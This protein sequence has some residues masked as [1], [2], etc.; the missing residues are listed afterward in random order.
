VSRQAEAAESEG[1]PLTAE[2]RRLVKDTRRAG[3]RVTHS[4]SPAEED[5]LCQELIRFD[6]LSMS[7]QEN[8]LDQPDSTWSQ[9]LWQYDGHF[10]T[11]LGRIT[12]VRAPAPLPP[13]ICSRQ[14]VRPRPRAFRTRRRRGNG[15]ARDRPRPSA[16]DDDPHDARRG[17]A[18]AGA[19]PEPLVAPE[20]LA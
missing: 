18:P 14:A 16:D 10:L 3:L 15:G 6:D 4:L 19:Q 20:A 13:A 9:Y 2:Q 7:E 8:E 1:T 17:P 5:A 12:P 11:I